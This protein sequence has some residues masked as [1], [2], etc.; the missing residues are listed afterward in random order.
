MAAQSFQIEGTFRIDGSW[1]PY[2]KVIEAPNEEQA[3]ERVFTL[4]GSQH[5]LKRRDIR[6]GKIE[7]AKGE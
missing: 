7:P 1:K 5:R 4:L 2:R 3:R 6:V